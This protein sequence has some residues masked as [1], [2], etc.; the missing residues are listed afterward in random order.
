MTL[1]IGIIVH[2]QPACR[3]TAVSVSAFLPVGQTVNYYFSR[4][5]CCRIKLSLAK[6]GSVLQF[7]STSGLCS[8]VWSC[9]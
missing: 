3:H 1:G 6:V 4:L 7:Y 8:T 9:S 2:H 5:C